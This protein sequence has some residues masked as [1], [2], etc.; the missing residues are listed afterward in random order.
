MK[1]YPHFEKAYNKTHNNEGFYAN[2][3]DDKGG[4]TYCG[5]SRRFHPSWQGWAI[6][7]SYSDKSQLKYDKVLNDMVKVFF[8]QNYWKANKLQYIDFDLLSAKLYDFGV[9]AGTG[10]A[11][12]FFQRALNYLG[13]NLKV[14]GV[15]G[16]NTLKEYNFLSRKDKVYV[17]EIVSGLQINH[18]VTI[19][20]KRPSQKKYARGWF[21]RV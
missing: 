3:P 1:I 6:I 13:S 21:K 16:K 19:T 7:D 11:G 4:E 9:N 14:D 20:E 18:Y 10:K 2:D 12:E 8:E 15:I 17:L 5:I